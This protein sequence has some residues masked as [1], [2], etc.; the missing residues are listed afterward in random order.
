MDDDKKGYYQQQ[1]ADA[2]SV[3]AL[4]PINNRIA[5]LNTAAPA[6]GWGEITK[7]GRPPKDDRTAPER[8]RNQ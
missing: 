4:V 2:V 3:S 5:S 1:N 7:N 8:C 6:P